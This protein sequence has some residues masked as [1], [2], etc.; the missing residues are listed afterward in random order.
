MEIPG[1]AKGF[2]YYDAERDINNIAPLNRMMADK[3]RIFMTRSVPTNVDPNNMP[4]IKFATGSQAAIPN[5]TAG[6]ID[7][8]ATKLQ[9]NPEPTIIPVMRPQHFEWIGKLRRIVMYPRTSASQDE[10]SSLAPVFFF[11]SFMSSQP[12]NKSIPGI[13]IAYP[14]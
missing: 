4:K 12:W 10:I 13:V 7:W 6:D 1:T 9:Q 11:R 5:A 8:D 3:N 2:V 14:V